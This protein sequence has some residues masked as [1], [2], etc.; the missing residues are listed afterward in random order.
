MNRT[1]PDQWPKRKPRAKE[2]LDDMT[3]DM[4]AFLRVAHERGVRPEQIGTDVK[5]EHG[6]VVKRFDFHPATLR[7][8][9]DHGLVHLVPNRKRRDVWRP[10]DDGRGLLVRH[11]PRLLM[12]LG[13]A[14]RGP[15]GGQGE[16]GYTHEPRLAWRSEPEVIDLDA[17]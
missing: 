12:P 15:E 6:Q 5:D 9:V 7:A 1:S 16:I 2:V 10:T 4:R 11:V 13:R 14:G 17:A 3:A 8:L